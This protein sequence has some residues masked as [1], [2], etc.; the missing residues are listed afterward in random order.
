[1]RSSPTFGVPCQLPV[2]REGKKEVH[3][4]PSGHGGNVTTENPS[5][6]ILKGNDEE[7]EEVEEFDEEDEDDMVERKE[8][9]EGNIGGNVTCH[10]CAVL[11]YAAQEE[12][13]N[14]N[15]MAAL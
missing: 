1:M 4:T 9:A 13:N 10:A 2:G 7:E 15:N 3:A 6:V 11:C 5:T 14:N 12:E 8:D